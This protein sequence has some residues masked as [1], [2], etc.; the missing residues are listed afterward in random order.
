MPPVYFL[1]IVKIGGTLLFPKEQPVFSSIAA[2]LRLLKK[3]AER[4][5]RR[6]GANHDGWGI[7]TLGQT[8]CLRCL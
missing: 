3:G 4:R 7:R 8:E 2:S 1:A 6:T 5:N